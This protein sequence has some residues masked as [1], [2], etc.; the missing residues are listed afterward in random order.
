MLS[1]QEIQKANQQSIAAIKERFAG[2]EA[3]QET[4]EKS[5]D[6][7]EDFFITQEGLDKYKEDLFKSIDAGEM[8]EDS[9]E[10][11]LDQISSLVKG[12]KEIDGK[13]VTVYTR[14]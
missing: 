2:S 9:L 11:S 5:K 14:S 6:S 1:E 13:E 4:I 12:T 8:T 10:K 7:K 3:K